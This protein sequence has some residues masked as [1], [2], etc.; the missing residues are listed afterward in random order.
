MR[1]RVMTFCVKFLL[2]EVTRFEWV[3]A[4]GGTNE[5]CDAGGEGSPA[6][7]PPEGSAP[8]HRPSPK[9]GCVPIPLCAML[10]AHSDPLARGESGR[11]I[12]RSKNSAVVVCCV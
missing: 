4:G 10:S 12:Y 2:D 1:A 7:E 5:Y 11:R 6:L 8:V 9:V 3:Q